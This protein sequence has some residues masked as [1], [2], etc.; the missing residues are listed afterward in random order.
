MF[1][2]KYILKNK[3]TKSKVEQNLIQMCYVTGGDIAHWFS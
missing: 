1:Y 3:Q 2:L